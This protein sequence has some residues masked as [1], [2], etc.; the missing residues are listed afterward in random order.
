MINYLDYLSV[1]IKFNRYFCNIKLNRN[2]FTENISH[3]IR[4]NRQEIAFT[5]AI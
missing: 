2:P 5:L 1:K 3:D 4:C